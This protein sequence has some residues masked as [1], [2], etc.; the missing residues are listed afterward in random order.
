MIV[1][2]IDKLSTLPSSTHS[3][4]LS[5]SLFFFP[6]PNKPSKKSKLHNDPPPL[7]SPFNSADDTN[8][9][10]TE[11]SDPTPPPPFPQETK[12]IR[13]IYSDTHPAEFAVSDACYERSTLSDQTTSTKLSHVLWH[14]NSI[15]SKER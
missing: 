5:L 6:S 7:L 2:H 8:P 1:T 4:S 14:F 9:K 15:I 12:W 3:L 13:T 11:S 10:E